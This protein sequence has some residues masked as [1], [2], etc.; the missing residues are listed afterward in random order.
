MGWLVSD[1]P[2]G[3]SVSLS[4][5]TTARVQLEKGLGQV[6]KATVEST[7]GRLGTVGAIAIDDFVVRLKAAMCDLVGTV[8]VQS[9]TVVDDVPVLPTSAGP[10]PPLPGS[11]QQDISVSSR[12]GLLMPSIFGDVQSGVPSS[13]QSA[14]AAKPGKIS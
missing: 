11:S 12:Q 10:F 5:L 1:V 2:R 4:D 6:V 14:S 8:P 9:S 3:G 13:V 7:L